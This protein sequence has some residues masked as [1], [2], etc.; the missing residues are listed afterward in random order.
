M[1]L[2]IIVRLYVIDDIKKDIP[3]FKHIFIWLCTE[4]ITDV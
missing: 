3:Q 2:G 4:R 1:L